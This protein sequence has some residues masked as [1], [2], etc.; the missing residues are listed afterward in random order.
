MYKRK[1][2]KYKSK[3]LEAKKQLGGLLHC[4]FTKF[5]N[6]IETKKIFSITLFFRGNI[7]DNIEE[8]FVSY[9]IG[10]LRSIDNV[11]HNFKDYKIRLYTAGII[12]NVDQELVTALVNKFQ[13]EVWSYNLTKKDE[14]NPNNGTYKEVF[15]KFIANCLLSKY[16]QIYIYDC[17]DEDKNNKVNMSLIGLFGAIVRYLPFFLK[18][19]K[20][21]DEIHIRDA[22]QTFGDRIDYYLIQTWKDLT[23]DNYGLSIYCPKHHD[24]Y[25]ERHNIHLDNFLDKYMPT[26]ALCGGKPIKK[27]Q[28]NYNEN[29]K[30]LYDEAMKLCM[31]NEEFNYGN[32]KKCTYGVDE[33]FAGSYLYQ[34]MKNSYINFSLQRVFNTIFNFYITEE[35]DIKLLSLLFGLD[36]ILFKCSFIA[37]KINKIETFLSN[38]EKFISESDRKNIG[39]II[40]ACIKCGFNSEII[41]INKLYADILSSFKFSTN[42]IAILNEI[43]IIPYYEKIIIEKKIGSVD[44]NSKYP[45][46]ELNINMIKDIEFLSF[47]FK[48]SRLDMEKFLIRYYETNVKEL[49]NIL[50]IDTDNRMMINIDSQQYNI[51][52]IFKSRHITLLSRSIFDDM[53]YLIKISD[54]QLY[55][56][57]DFNVDIGK[58]ISDDLKIQKLYKFVEINS[59]YCYMYDFIE[60]KTLNDILK[61]EHINYNMFKDICMQL[62]DIIITLKK[63]KLAYMDINENN[64]IINN[65]NIYLIDNELMIKYG[66]S[67][68]ELGL[69][70]NIEGIDTRGY[71]FNRETVEQYNILIEDERFDLFSFGKVLINIIE[72]NNNYPYKNDIINYINDN[73]LPTTG[74]KTAEFIKEGLNN[75]FN[76]K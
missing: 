61:T 38:I 50:Y 3:Y 18:E 5:N 4:S 75:I 23:V 64:I 10:I 67:V 22:D 15:I 60:G 6:D 43:L 13:N 34:Y 58:Y 46:I 42:K 49:I 8:K 14:L 2:L 72:K 51:F 45:T 20:S 55:I 7:N 53:K 63:Y 37:Y 40:N 73:I 65:G 68:K 39:P 41:K 1:Y 47:I 70:I 29:L 52:H 71:D 27:F 24:L 44:I 17:N 25:I 19:D 30:V 35:Y 16:V 56:N 26:Y 31:M 32:E 12:D 11:I 48:Y 62:L 33:I 57:N 69:Y 36:Y 54:K 74:E 66:S 21:L 9:I 76:K 59:Y 28:D